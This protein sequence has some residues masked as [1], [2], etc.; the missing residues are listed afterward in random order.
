LL[1]ANVHLGNFTDFDHAQYFYWGTF[2]VGAKFLIGLVLSYIRLNHGMK[3]AMIFHGVYN[4]ILII[5]AIYFYE[6]GG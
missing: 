5:P 4:A 3:W 2:L 1:F 6:V